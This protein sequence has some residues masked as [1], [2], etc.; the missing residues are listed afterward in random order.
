ML[1]INF[2]KEALA[3]LLNFPQVAPGAIHIQPLRGCSGLHRLGFKSR[4]RTDT[5]LNPVGVECE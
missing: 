3:K 4:S 1:F 5:T 2:F